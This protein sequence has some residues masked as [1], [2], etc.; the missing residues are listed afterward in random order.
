MT[1]PH[2]PGPAMKNEIEQAVRDQVQKQ[3][4]M[5]YAEV[6]RIK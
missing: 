5:K 3:K 4:M 1:T 2:P 6:E